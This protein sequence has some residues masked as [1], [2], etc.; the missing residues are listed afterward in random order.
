MTHPCK[1]KCPNFTDEHCC[2]CLV[3]EQN[4]SQAFNLNDVVATAFE[5]LGDDKNI[6]NHVSP[7]CIVGG[8]Q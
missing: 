3:N 4:G 8:D 5:D 1:N 2:H 7:Q 6:E